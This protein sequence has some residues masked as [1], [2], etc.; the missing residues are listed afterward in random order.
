MH[1]W[2]YILKQIFW[3]CFICHPLRL[4]YLNPAHQCVIQVVVLYVRMPFIA[5]ST[6]EW[7]DMNKQWTVNWWEHNWTVNKLKSWYRKD[8][9]KQ[10]WLQICQHINIYQSKIWLKNISP[11]FPHSLQTPFIINQARSVSAVNQRFIPRLLILSVTSHGKQTT[12]SRCRPARHGAF[13]WQE[14]PLGH[15]RRITLTFF[16]SWAGNAVEDVNWALWLHFNCTPPFC[17]SQS[18]P[19]MSLNHVLG[20]EV[21][22]TDA[23]L[24]AICA[25]NWESKDTGTQKMGHAKHHNHGGIEVNSWRKACNVCMTFG[26]MK[27][28]CVPTRR[29]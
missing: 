5:L 15:T 8:R 3:N 20:L 4:L 1:I 2:N 16:L 17:Y 12:R 13:H 19:F 7:H 22:R 26:W 14:S 24:R 23:A 29:K 18:D 9:R 25:N 27:T 11:I 21:Q 10:R 6:S 28:T